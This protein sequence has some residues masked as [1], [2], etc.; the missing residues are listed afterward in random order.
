MNGKVT[1]PYGFQC[2][3]DHM[4]KPSRVSR[5]ESLLIKKESLQTLKTILVFEG[6]NIDKSEGFK[7]SVQSNLH[8]KHLFFSLKLGFIQEIKRDHFQILIISTC[9][10]THA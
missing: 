9:T 5:T 4:L 8:P 10:H 3:T 7:T 2:P 1:F 6:K